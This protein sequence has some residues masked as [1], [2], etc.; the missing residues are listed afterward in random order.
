MRHFNF[1]YKWVLFSGYL[2]VILALCIDVVAFFKINL[3]FI[4]ETFWNS[5]IPNNTEGFYTFIL[6]LYCS[7]LLAFGVCVIL[8]ARNGFYN[9]LRW[10]WVALTSSYTIWFVADTFYSL[11]TAVYSNTILNTVLYIFLIIPLVSTRK[12]FLT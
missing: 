8:I 5:G 10:A 12:V 9:K 3:P 6:G 1:W 2:I 7:L 11:Y 4:S